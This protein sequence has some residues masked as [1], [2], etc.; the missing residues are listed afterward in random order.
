MVIDPPFVN[1]KMFSRLQNS[2]A[3]ARSLSVLP[4]VECTDLP[5]RNHNLSF[6]RMLTL[7]ARNAGSRP[8]PGVLRRILSA[9]A[10]KIPKRARPTVH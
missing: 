3:Y 7:G 8:S 9:C 4:L 5:P 1:K 10:S 6:V 2:H